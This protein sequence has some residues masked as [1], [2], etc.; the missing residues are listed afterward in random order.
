[1][2]E[3]RLLLRALKH[4]A[5]S[6]EIPVVLRVPNT[7]FYLRPVAVLPNKL[8]SGDVGCLTKWRNQYVDAFLTRFNATP[9]RTANWLCNT[10]ASDDS[11]ILFMLEEVPFSPC[12]YLGLAFIDWEKE[13]GEADAIVRGV[14][15]PK[16]TMSLALRALMHFA[17]STLSLKKLGVRVLSDNP[18]LT[19]YKKA[20][21]VETFREP[22]AEKTISGETTFTEAPQNTNPKLWLVHHTYQLPYEA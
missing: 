17:R 11:K 19:F 1:M 3:G 12:G 16:G 14:E 22:L 21:F 2:S 9:E 15:A 5:G 18:A 10:I 8:N 6:G 7:N 13:S 4:T 20:G